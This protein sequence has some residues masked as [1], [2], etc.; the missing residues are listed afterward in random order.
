MSATS[1][2]KRLIRAVAPA[3][4]LAPIERRFFR[5]H[6]SGNYPTWEAARRNSTGYDAPAIL[7]KVVAAARLVR[8]GQAAYERDGVVFTEPAANESLLGVLGHA[9]AQSG[10]RLSVVDFGGALGSAYWQHRQWFKPGSTVRW[11][12][13]EQSHFVAIGRREFANEQ[14]TFHG[15]IDEACAAI[16]PDVLLLSSVLGYL[17]NPHDL[18]RAA[19][20]RGFNHI[21]IDRTGLIEGPTDCLTVQHV[22]RS[23]Y[24]ASYPCW[25][26]SRDRLLRHFEADYLVRAEYTTADGTSD[27]RT[28]KG[29]QLERRER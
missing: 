29:L 9:A 10:G 20:A 11:G 28:F 26:L 27:G 21:L 16:Q 24:R 23:V 17:E 13:V 22:P 25:F 8:D 6:W 14:L 19:V 2:V 15:S 18:L 5:V 3:S 7:T 1:R 4:W 12:V